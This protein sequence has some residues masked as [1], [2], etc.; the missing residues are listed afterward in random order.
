MNEDQVRE[1]INNLDYD[2]EAKQRF[3]ARLRDLYVRHES[4]LSIPLLC[5]IMLITFDQSADIPDK[6]H[7][8]F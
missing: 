8:F 2:K 3:L 5:I 6:K 7:I 1:L 4:F